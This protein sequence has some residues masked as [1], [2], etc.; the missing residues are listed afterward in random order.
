MLPDGIHKTR[1]QRG[2]IKRAFS[3]E[4]EFFP[5]K[6]EV[7]FTTVSQWKVSLVN[8]R[9]DFR[10]ALRLFKLSSLWYNL[11]SR[12]LTVILVLGTIRF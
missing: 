9:S 8:C 6:K 5:V 4:G 10:S 12:K 1:R 7:I 2:R 11:F 3:Q